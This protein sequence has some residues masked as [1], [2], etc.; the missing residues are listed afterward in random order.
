MN[1]NLKLKEKIF[2][3]LS[4]FMLRI[5]SKYIINFSPKIIKV[6]RKFL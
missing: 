5:F 2:I 6:G 1:R 4:D 3:F